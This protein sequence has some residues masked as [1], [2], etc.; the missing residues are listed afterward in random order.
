MA[1]DLNTLKNNVND[2]V[3]QINNL[4]IEMIEISDYLTSLEVNESVYSKNETIEKINVD[5]VVIK[6]SI[7]SNDFIINS[8]SIKNKN[9]QL[10]FDNSLTYNNKIVKVDG[11]LIMP[12]FVDYDIKKDLI[13]GE[14]YIVVTKNNIKK[15]YLINYRNNNFKCGDFKIQ[16]NKIITDSE[17]YVRVR[18]A[19]NDS[20]N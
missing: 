5:K 20:T 16:D 18:G 8:N 2:L 13:P 4:D 3:A 17:I 15:T 19:K 12:G 7:Y 1:L 10:L 14:Y 11:N 9:N 6:G